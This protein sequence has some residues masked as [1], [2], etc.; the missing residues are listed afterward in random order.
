MSRNSEVWMTSE[1]CSLAEFR[2]EVEIETSKESYPLADLIARNV[3]VYDAANLRRSL[4]DE[5][6]ASGLMAE[7]HRIFLDG[8]GVVV[9]RGTY[10]DAALIDGVST[11]LLQIIDDERKA[12]GG[13]GDH[14]AKAGANARVWNSHEKLC[15]RS[16]E[17]YARYASNEFIDLISRSWLGPL[18]QITAQVN[19]VYPGGAA[20]SPHRDYHMGF[21]QADQLRHYPAHVH[22]LSAALTLQGAIAHCDMP[23]ESGPTK[24]LPY[25]QRHLPGY[26]ATH[27]PE[28]RDYFETHHVQLPLAKGD[29][30]FFNPALFHAAGTNTTKSTLRLANLLQIG[31]GFGRSIE[32]VDRA[33]MTKHLYPT[34]CTMRAAGTLSARDVDCL[35]AAT[36]EGYPFPCNL[37]LD[38]PLSGM[39]PPS[40]QDLLRQALA[41]AWPSARLNDAIDA[42]GGRRRSH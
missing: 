37:D 24:I 12:T 1:S 9:I 26:F 29:S 32:I 33:R 11:I 5:R 16:P 28:F 6:S 4:P 19:L 25:S 40:Q 7:W 23:V 38:S 20:Q 10:A 34:L 31:S 21:L 39:A 36:A 41:E 27:R 18:Y 8:P 15:L 14:F 22:R 42:H 17:L 35:I 13:Q 3:P 2:R 30:M